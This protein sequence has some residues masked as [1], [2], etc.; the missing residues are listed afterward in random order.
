MHGI[1]HLIRDFT[2]TAVKEHLRSQLDSGEAP[3]LTRNETELLRFVA[4]RAADW[5]PLVS[6]DL[7]QIP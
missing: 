1:R 4:Q 7:T 6:D 5:R 3:K 2:A